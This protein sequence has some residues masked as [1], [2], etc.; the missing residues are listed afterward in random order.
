MKSDFD[1]FLLVP[2]YSDLKSRSEADISSEMIYKLDKFRTPFVASP[3][4]SCETKMAIAME[5]SGGFGTIHRYQSENSQASMIKILKQKSI[6]IRA[7][8]IGSNGV[9]NRIK[10]LVDAGAN[11]LILDAAHGHNL[12]CMT[13][14]TY[15]KKEYDDIKVISANIVT[16][17][18]A[19]DY[20]DWGADALRV[21][22]GSGSSCETR[23]VAGVGRNV[24]EAIMDISFS[25][26]KI[27]ILCDGGLRFSG[28]VAKAV[29]AGAS[30]VI[31]G[32]L[33]ATTKESALKRVKRGNKYYRKYSGMSS[34]EALLERKRRTGENGSDHFNAPEGKTIYL[35]DK[36]ETI[37]NVITR[38][39]GGLR[40]SL[41]YL[42]AKNIPEMWTRA[43]WCSI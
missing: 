43:E 23:T 8:S 26:V 28:D 13:T 15:I 18:A 35:E 33:F 40:H 24:I 20:V 4:M 31:I 5:K 9:E 2:Q 36:N 7:A 42:G 34:P 11:V 39:S 19:K 6:K 10:K 16:V 22:I 38:L 32:N 41:A 17:E 37:D 21:S 29:A 1:K 14:T 3:M 27:P 30:G 25:D 12:S